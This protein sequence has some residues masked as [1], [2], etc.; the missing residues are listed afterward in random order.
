M[1]ASFVIFAP[2]PPAPADRT[3]FLRDGFSVGAFLFGPFWLAYRRAFREAAAVALLFLL[4]GVGAA[5]VGASASAVFVLSLALNVALGFEATQLVAWS[6]RRR[7]LKEQGVVVAQSLDEAEEHYF[8][9]RPTPPPP[10]P[11]PE[12][13]G[14]RF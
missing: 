4:I 7:G 8:R 13:G 11:F 1:A 10:P 5:L 2:E 9:S 12:A 14:P 3:I 6:Y